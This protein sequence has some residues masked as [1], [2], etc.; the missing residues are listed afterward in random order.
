MSIESIGTA[1][2]TVAKPSSGWPPTRW[3]GL[4]RRHQL[5]VLGLELG[6]PLHH[7]VVFAVADLRL[8]LDVIEVVMPVQL[9]RAAAATSCSISLLAMASLTLGGF[10]FDRAVKTRGRSPS[11][12]RRSRA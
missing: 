7:P 8:G 4:S 12:G 1:C 2:R 11:P 3:V 10:G 5:G 6:Q 9:A